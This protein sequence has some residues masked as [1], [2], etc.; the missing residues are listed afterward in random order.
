MLMDQLGI[1]VPGALQLLQK[2]GSVR[3]AMKSAR[4]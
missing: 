3:K 4:A 2:H 1:D